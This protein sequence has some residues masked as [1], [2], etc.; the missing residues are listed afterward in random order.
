MSMVFKKMVQVWLLITSFISVAWAHKEILILLGAPGTGKGT[1][2]QRC[3]DQFNFK[4]LS[5]GNLCRQEIASGSA[6]GEKIAYYS[7]TTG[8]T[9]DDIIAE[10]VE[11]WLA[12][13]SG[14][15]KII[16]DGYPRTQAQAVRLSSFLEQK[17]SGYR[18][19]VFYL[20][21]LDYEELVQRIFNRLI[22][23]N[24]ECQAV[25][26][27]ML[28][29]DKNKDICEKCHGQLIQRT[30]DTEDIIRIRIAGFVH[31]NVEIIAYYQHIGVSVT[32]IPVSHVTPERVFEKFK[33]LAT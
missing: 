25:Y 29:K 26:N 17:F 10:I 11:A 19:N 5:T 4:V 8:L 30:D 33:S 7:M 31:H 9:P 16:F 3:C 20:E 12:K 22:C 1:L 24:R 18:L 13:Q 21:T 14:D 27:R 28:M 32:K 2:A 15:E 6:L 23:G